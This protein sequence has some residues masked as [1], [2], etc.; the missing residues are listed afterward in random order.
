M[1]RTSVSIE[2]C[3]E[4]TEGVR[5][6]RDSGAD[7]AEL[8]RELWTGGLTPTVEVVQAALRVAPRGG[9]RILIREN[10]SSFELTDEQIQRQARDIE[11][12]V[13]QLSPGGPEVG[14]V[15]GGLRGGRINVDAARLWRRAARHHY[16]VFH[17]AFDQVQDQT[18]AL[19]QLI[20]LG[21]DAVLT[22]GGTTGSADPQGLARLRRVADGRITVIGSGGV[23]KHNVHSVVSD[24]RLTDVHFRIPDEGD[25]MEEVR[26][27]VQ[28]IRKL[29]M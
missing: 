7:R 18:G 14:F 3:V 8:A 29:E 27:L 11:T 2:L 20:D 9:L 16:L 26:S 17:R 22:T 28:L 15:V 5:I 12:L 25:P 1:L 21:Y 24:G 13:S 6:A 23:R 10:P 19:L 4:D